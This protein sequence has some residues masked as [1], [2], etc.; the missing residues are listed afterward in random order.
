MGEEEE[1]ED[2]DDGLNGDNKEEEE[3]E[4]KKE[5]NVDDVKEKKT[6]YDTISFTENEFCKEVQVFYRRDFKGKILKIVGIRFL[7]NMTRYLI[8]KDCRIRNDDEDILIDCKVIT[9]ARKNGAYGLSQIFCYVDDES[10]VNGLRF[11]FSKIRKPDDNA[12]E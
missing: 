10:F 8:G 9:P 2:G 12:P 5:N 11:K 6:N 3:E 7:T 1:E 4:E